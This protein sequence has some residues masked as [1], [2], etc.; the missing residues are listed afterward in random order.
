M[1]T[2][3]LLLLST[4]LGLLSVP[5]LAQV[6]D[7]YVIPAAANAGGQGGSNW[8]T[9]FSIFNP[10]LEDELVVSLT[11]LPS[12]GIEG[13][14]VLIELPPNAL[15]YSDNIL[16][17][18]FDFSGTGALLVATFPE[19]NPH[20]PN[21]I[22]NRAFLV[23]TDTYNDQPHGTYG[24]TIP[25][26]W[27]G[28]MDFDTDG[29]SSVAHGIRNGNGWRTNV[30]AVNLGFCEVTVFVNIYDMDGNLV[31]QEIP[32]DVPPLGHIQ[33]RLP[34][35]LAGGS[36]EFFVVDPCTADDDLYAVVFPYT[37]TIDQKTN[38]PAYQY[39]TLLASTDILA[40]KGQ[41]I[42]PLNVGKKIDIE[43]ARKV[44]SKVERKGTLNL[45][46]TERGWAIAN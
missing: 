29:I 19:D 10:H 35:A 12:F 13:D 28:L 46:R 1:K 7:T 8:K 9:R 44:R 21:E 23:N 22:L 37:S 6:T 39:P 3:R 24:Q 33:D 2:S 42:D 40:A 15:F 30:G 14:E 41:K 31:R 20:L 16:D 43:H 18:A 4:L 11:L 38:D 27:T 34:V 25:G 17:D 5:A 32:L 26:T 45:M 36:V